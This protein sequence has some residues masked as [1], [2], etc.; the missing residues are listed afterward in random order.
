MAVHQEK[1]QVEVQ[2]GAE[3]VEG[4]LNLKHDHE[5]LLKSSLDD[6]GLWATVKRFRKVRFCS[7]SKCLSSY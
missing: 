2:P 3:H 1:V 5:V 4:D 6:L 7:V